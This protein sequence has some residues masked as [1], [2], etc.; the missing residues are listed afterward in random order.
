MCAELK[1]NGGLIMVGDH[2]GHEAG[3]EGSSVTISY[4]VEEGR[5][6]PLSKS[7]EAAGGE[8]MQ[9]PTM[10]FWGQGEEM[11]VCDRMSLE[12]TCSGGTILRANVVEGSR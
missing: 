2:C 6:G 1:V 10:A 7:F 12:D 8:I 3:K 4:E 11:R 5:A 9:E